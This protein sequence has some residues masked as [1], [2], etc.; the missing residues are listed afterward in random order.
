LRREEEREAEAA[1]ALRRQAARLDTAILQEREARRVEAEA[2]AEEERRRARVRV[3]A[4]VRLEAEAEEERRR[5]AETL[6][7]TLALTEREA[8][9]AKRGAEA[10][11][12]KADEAWIEEHREARS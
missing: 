9:E 7:L 2:E 12:R 10:A 4:A 3:S 1:E 6:T 11:R 8:A 5:A